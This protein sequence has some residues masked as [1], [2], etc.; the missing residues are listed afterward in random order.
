MIRGRAYF[1]NGIIKPINNY[2]IINDDDVYFIIDG[3]V[4]HYLSYIDD[5]LE[6]L[7]KSNDKICFKHRRHDFYMVTDTDSRIVDIEKIEI[8]LNE[9]E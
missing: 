5:D 1:S 9:G 7:T 3:T 8:L 2:W 6:V 4:Y